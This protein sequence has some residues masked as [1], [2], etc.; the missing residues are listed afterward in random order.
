MSKLSELIETYQEIYSQSKQWQD[1]LSTISYVLTTEY[2]KI[3]NNI[4]QSFVH[5]EIEL[6]MQYHA[7][8]YGYFVVRTVMVAGVL[9]EA[10]VS[11]DVETHVIVLFNSIVDKPSYLI[12]VDL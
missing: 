10:T 5:A 1:R 7:H 3:E 11:V 12:S 6:Q 8:Y 4:F 2:A 9:Y